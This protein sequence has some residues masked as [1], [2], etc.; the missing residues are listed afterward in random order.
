MGVGSHYWP[1]AD[2]G[3][4]SLHHVNEETCYLCRPV[5][6]SFIM[7]DSSYRSETSL[8]GLIDLIMSS[9]TIM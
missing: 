1:E 2:A 4:L 6:S 3:D 8:D 9:N 5:N 7:E